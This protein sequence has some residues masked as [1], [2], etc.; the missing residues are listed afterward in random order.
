MVFRS[1]V[2][3]NLLIRIIYPLKRKSPSS[4]CRV[5]ASFLYAVSW[6]VIAVVSGHTHL[7]RFHIS[8]M[9]QSQQKSSAFSSAKI[10]K[11]PLWQTVWTQ[12]RLFL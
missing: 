11:K 9:R 6:S 7:S 5:G 8:L 1:F 10:F 12:I 3:I 4:C 2:K